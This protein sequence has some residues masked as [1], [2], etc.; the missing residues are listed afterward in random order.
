[1]PICK[2]CRSAQV[3]K[4]GFVRGKQR[5]FCKECGANFI[6]GD[7]RTNEEIVLKKCVGIL[8]YSLG[9]V[10][11]STLARILGTWPSLSYRWIKKSGV[12][13]LKG[14]ASHDIQ[15]MQFEELGAFLETQKDRFGAKG[16]VFVGHG[17]LWSGCSTIIILQA[18]PSK[19]AL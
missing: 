5:F 17:E 19:P 14:P 12:Q 1:M 13:F 2:K 3:I 18:S 9:K 11:F 10:S 4:N 15:E 16:K 8:L 7:G 6:E